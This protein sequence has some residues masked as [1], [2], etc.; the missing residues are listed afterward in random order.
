M[1]YYEINAY[2]L[3]RRNIFEADRIITLYS[4]EMG[5][6]SAIAKGVR[7]AKAKLAGNLEPFNKCKIR[8]VK[9]RNLDIIIGSEPAKMHDYSKLST[10]QLQVLYLISEI[11]NRLSAEHQSNDVA[12]ELF[13]ESID[14]LLSNINES[15]VAQY[16]GLNFLRSIG[17]QPELI[18]TQQHSR[19]YLGYDSGKITF[20]KPNSH[21]GII[22]ESTI[23]LWRLIL[24]NNL[25]KLQ[26]VTNIDKQLEQGSKLML[27]YYEY[28]FDFKSKSLKVFQD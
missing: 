16:F 22:S 2:I 25:T 4:K 28:H 1:N 20:E 10:N 3:T 11:L 15:L 13:G 19:H 14:A 6:L 5:K 23:K 12:F 18:D 27:H 7:L 9:G 26:K 17:S 8:L 21:Y 24:S